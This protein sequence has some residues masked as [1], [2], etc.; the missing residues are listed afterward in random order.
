[1]PFRRFSSHFQ[2]ESQH[3]LAMFAY[4]ARLDAAQLDGALTWLA[5]KAETKE[6]KHL[7]RAPALERSHFRHVFI[8]FATPNGS[9]LMGFL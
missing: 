6:E 1:M 7:R 8:C 9:R 2:G 3:S 5:S 4:A